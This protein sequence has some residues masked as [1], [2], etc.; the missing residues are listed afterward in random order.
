LALA[1]L[2][3]V[4]LVGVPAVLFAGILLAT[5][6]GTQIVTYIGVAVGPLM[7]CFLPWQPAA[8]LAQSW[9]KF[10]I[11]A[12]LTYVVAMTLAFIC[13]A[14]AAS[15]TAA[16]TLA[17]SVPDTELQ[18]L[19]VIAVILPLAATLGTTILF[20]AWLMHKSEDI[21]QAIVSGG[22]SSSGGSFIAVLSRNISKMGGKGASTPKPK[23]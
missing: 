15:V 18:D 23:S 7:I 13:K 16:M 20:M 12:G 10:M 6:F 1:V 4:V 2:I 19:G 5:L 14:G 3:F 17:L 8:W 21:A 11:T 9:L 22:A